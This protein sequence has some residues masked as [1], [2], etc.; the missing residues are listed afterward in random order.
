MSDWTFLNKHR[1]KSGQYGSDPSFG[2]NGAFRFNVPGEVRP[3]CVIASDGYGWQHVSVSFGQNCK[4]CPS[5]EVMCA[6]KDLFWEPDQCVVQFHPPSDQHVNNH[7]GCLH[8]WRCTDGREQPMPPSLLV[9]IP[10][11]KGEQAT[12]RLLSG[13]LMVD[14]KCIPI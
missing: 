12:K 6:V 11:V 3:V 10:G 5:W 1:L 2:F 13:F 4:R 7:E 14:G 8:L 9:G